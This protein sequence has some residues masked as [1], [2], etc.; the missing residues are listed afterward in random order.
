[1]HEVSAVKLKHTVMNP[2]PRASE[3]Q[4]REMRERLGKLYRLGRP[5]TEVEVR[6]A[7]EVIEGGGLVA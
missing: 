4:L 3:S 7:L 1:M 2:D 5:M 6:H